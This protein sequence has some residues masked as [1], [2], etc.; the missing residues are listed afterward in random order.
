MALKKRLFGYSVK[1]V[2]GLVS[3]YESMIDLQRRDIEFL[4][5]DN[6]LLKST[7]SRITKEKA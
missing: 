3:D 4:K 6:E 1:D 2:D 7:I 5:N